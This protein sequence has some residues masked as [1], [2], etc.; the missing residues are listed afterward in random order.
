M[1]Q[2]SY[3]AFVF[4]SPQDFLLLFHT[5]CD[6]DMS[7][8]GRGGVIINIGSSAMQGGREEQGAYAA[9]KAGI[10]AFTETLALEGKELGVFAYCIVPRRT[11]TQ[12]RAQL[13]PDT[14]W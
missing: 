2:R 12:L 3:E 7:G 11:D 4:F 5:I 9:S 8:S 14:V 6:L 10:Q 13:C 1:Q